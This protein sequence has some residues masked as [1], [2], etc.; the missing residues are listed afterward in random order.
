MISSLHISRSKCL[1]WVKRLRDDDR[2]NLLT[3]IRT[4]IV[5]H[6]HHYRSV[7]D[8]QIVT[9]S[10]FFWR[11]VIYDLMLSKL[12]MRTPLIAWS[13]HHKKWHCLSTAVIDALTDSAGRPWLIVHDAADIFFSND[14]TNEKNWGLV[15]WSFVSRKIYVFDGHIQIE[16]SHCLYWSSWW[17]LTRWNLDAHYVRRIYRI[18]HIL[19]ILSTDSWKSLWRIARLQILIIRRLWIIFW[20]SLGVRANSNPYKKKPCVNWSKNWYQR[21]YIGHAKRKQS[22]NVIK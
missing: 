10:F 22:H 17:R 20:A 13:G 7:L 3:P 18:F 21:K 14:F 5:V 12:S 16:I 15:L 1:G 2:D 9:V 8:I 4:K 19:A 11:F 6:K